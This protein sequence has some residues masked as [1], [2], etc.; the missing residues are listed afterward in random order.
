MGGSEESDEFPS[1][2]SQE[3]KEPQEAGHDGTQD[4]GSL[5]EEGVVEKKEAPS[6]IPNVPPSSQPC[7]HEI[8]TDLQNAD[9]KNS[10]SMDLLLSGEFTSG[11]RP[12]ECIEVPD[13][14]SPKTLITDH[15]E[16]VLQ[17]GRTINYFECPDCGFM[18]EVTSGQRPLEVT[19]A[20]CNSRF[21]LKGRKQEEPV[22][23]E[24]P[25]EETDWDRKTK[26]SEEAMKYHKRGDLNRAVE[27]YDEIL[28]V[29][30]NDPVVWNNKGVALDGLGMH[31]LAI[32]CYEKSI[33]IRDSY[34]DAW[35]NYA[36]SQYRMKQFEKATESLRKLL[37]L[38]PDHTEGNQ[39]FDKCEEELREWKKFL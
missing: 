18:I 7:G 10:R 21:R 4:K 29:S 28:E 3:R 13:N 12:S 24:E 37:Q 9:V 31:I 27:L 32:K 38:K 11:W 30:S 39:L 6:G 22:I 19:C 36:Y 20:S 33:Q 17:E 26:L 2:A 5:I 35:F 14:V 8:P 34:I 23:Q 25:P 16:A 15:P 1:D